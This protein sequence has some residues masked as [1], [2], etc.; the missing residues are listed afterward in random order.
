[1]R[2]TAP[3]TRTRLVMIIE[4][5]SSFIL[6]WW[7]ASDSLLPQFALY[8][9]AADGVD[10]RLRLKLSGAPVARVDRIKDA[11]V[12]SVECLLFESLGLIRVGAA[13][14][15]ADSEPGVKIGNSFLTAFVGVVTFAWLPPRITQSDL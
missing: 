4:S 6:K 7:T 11:T 5:N 8:F 1:M 9:G 10:D 2:Q 12:Q 14:H 3:M 13:R 15:Q